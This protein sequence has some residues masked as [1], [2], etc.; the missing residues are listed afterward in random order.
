MP[1][2]SVPLTGGSGAG[3]EQP[4][5]PPGRAVSDQ[6]LPAQNQPSSSNNAAPSSWRSRLQDIFDAYVP[7]AYYQRLS[8]QEFDAGNYATAAGYEAAALADAALGV[9]TLGASTS[10]R[11]P[12]TTL[13]RRSFRSFDQL[14]THLGR[15][16]EEMAWH[17]IVEQSQIPQFGAERI[18]SVDNIVAIPRRVNI[19]LNA[20]YGSKT[21]YSEGKLVRD[22]LKTQSFE[23]QYEFGMQQLKEYL[24]Y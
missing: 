4:L 21:R 8:Q 22:W 14:K 3:R 1:Q 18:H 11:A 23:D 24:G 13:F 5:A 19:E 20:L 10:L 15:A 16:P 2:L 12:A 9:A 17:H 6:P 7:G